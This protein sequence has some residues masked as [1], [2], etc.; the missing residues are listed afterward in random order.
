MIRK[1]SSFYKSHIP[2]MVQNTRLSRIVFIVRK[3]HYHCILIYTLIFI[4]AV[5]NCQPAVDFY[6]INLIDWGVLPTPSEKTKQ[7]TELCQ[8]RF[9]G[10]PALVVEVIDDDPGPSPED[11]EKKKLE[12][13]LSG[14]DSAEI[15]VCRNNFTWLSSS[16]DNNHSLIPGT[17]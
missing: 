6:S 13:C 17:R 1:C 11:I 2:N 5:C 9:Q 15:H 16:R 8:L 7:L 3:N 4:L 10:D 12:I 14:G